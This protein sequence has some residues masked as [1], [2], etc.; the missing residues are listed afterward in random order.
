MS[1]PPIP[2]IAS[3]LLFVLTTLS[4]AQ[5]EASRELPQAAGKELVESMCTA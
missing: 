5:E 1:R 4:Y 3:A 2:L